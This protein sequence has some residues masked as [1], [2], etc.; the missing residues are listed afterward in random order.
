[1]GTALGCEILNDLG[2]F[3]VEDE[4][5][6]CVERQLHRRGGVL[7][8]RVEGAFE[9]GQSVIVDAA[10]P[11]D[12]RGEIAKRIDPSLLV[13]ELQPRDTQS[14]DLEL[15]ARGQ[16]ALDP[17]KTLAGAEL[18][19]QLIRI[20]FGKNPGQRPGRFTGIEDLPR[21]GVKRWAV[22]RCRQELAVA[23]DKIG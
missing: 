13:L 7:N 16:T 20:E 14:V 23:V 6:P 17:D 11:D 5:H 19:L 21:V 12:M 22:E 3:L 2:Q 9:P 10:K 18:A 8:G 1:A 4:L 15:L